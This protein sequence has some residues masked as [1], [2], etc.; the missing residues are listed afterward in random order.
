MKP[1]RTNH[2][3]VPHSSKSCFGFG[4][5]ALDHSLRGGLARGRLHEFYGARAADAIAV[6]GLGLVLA[7]QAAERGKI[8]WVR[9]DH[10]RL[11]AGAPSAAGLASL[12]L[13][14]RR[15]IL[16]EARDML[17][18]LRA[19]LEGARCAGLYSL[20]LD[21]WGE[22]RVFDLTASR[23]LSLAAQKSGVTLFVL[24]ASAQPAASSAE[25]RWQVKA[26]PSKAWAA[27]APGFPRFELTLLRDRSFSSSV[28]NASWCVEWNSESRSFNLAAEDTIRPPLS[29][30]VVPLPVNRQAWD[31]RRAS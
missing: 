10:G 11:E 8:I 28:A 16:V 5:P 30:P 25:T 19:A 27:N 12:G 13:D 1:Q 24:R 7:A 15:F 4:V 21:V 29:R 14:H 22:H 18:A 3:S 2:H 20:V 17:S 9:Q 6:T 31:Y 23:R 26:A